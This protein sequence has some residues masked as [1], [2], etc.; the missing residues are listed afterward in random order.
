MNFRA[1]IVDRDGV[2]TDFEMAPAAAY[3]SPL[4]P[5]SLW[6][7]SDRWEAWGAKVGFPRNMAEERRFFAGFWD[8]LADE[9]GLSEAARAALHAFDYTSY[10]RPFADVR[11]ALDAAQQ[12]GLKIGV[13]SNFTLASLEPSLEATGLADAVDAA[14]AATVIG[15]SKPDVKAYRIAAAALGVEPRECLFFDDEQPCVDGARA[16]GMTAYLVDRRRNEHDL[17]QGVV[18]DLSGIAAAL[19]QETA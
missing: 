11:P 12:A 2:L 1:I 19:G 7:M 10:L 13:L 17:A 6:E 4:L 14:C 9:F 16:A 3:F 8:A 18:C 15:A 5:I